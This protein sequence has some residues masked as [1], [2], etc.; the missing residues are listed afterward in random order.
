MVRANSKRA[1]TTLSPEKI[2]ASKRT[3]EHLRSESM[4]DF[5]HTT[6]KVVIG[7]A[8]LAIPLLYIAFLI[9]NWQD[10]EA[11]NEWMRQGVGASLAFI[12][13]KAEFNFNK[14][15]EG[16]SSEQEAF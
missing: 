5:M 4:K 16:G 15:N 14:S 13:G 8:V 10:A 12:L 6:K 3:Q 7:G 2:D 1:G 11:R 9:A